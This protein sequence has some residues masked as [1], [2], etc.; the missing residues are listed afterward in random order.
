ML[1]LALAWSHCP[2]WPLQNNFQRLWTAHSN[3]T[4]MRYHLVVLCG[5]SSEKNHVFTPHFFEKSTPEGLLD[6]S[7]AFHECG[8]KTIYL[9]PQLQSPA[10]PKWKSF[11]RRKKPTTSQTDRSSAL[12]VLEQHCSA[13]DGRNQRREQEEPQTMKVIIPAVFIEPQS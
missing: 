10:V 3:K 2:W 8:L 4:V 13:A 11:P 12:A 1:P 5:R 7:L 9:S 6:W